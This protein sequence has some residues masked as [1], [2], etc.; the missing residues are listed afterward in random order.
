MIRPNVPAER[1]MAPGAIRWTSERKLALLRDIDSGKTTLAQAQRDFA[2][3]AAE[4]DCWRARAARFGSKGLKV[5]H[6][7]DLRP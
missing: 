5:R 2:V 4:V 6:I 7:A 1:Y 3:S